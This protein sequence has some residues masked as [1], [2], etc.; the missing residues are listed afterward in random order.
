MGF[1][2][3]DEV[4]RISRR[5][6]EH[7][8][9]GNEPVFEQ[10]GQRGVE[11]TVAGEE[12]GVRQDA[13]AAELLDDSALGE[14]HRKNVT[15]GGQSD[16]DRKRALGSGTHNIAEEGSCK[17]APRREDLIL[18]HGGEVGD[19]GEHVKD[20]NA[21]E[22]HGS[23]EFE[24]SDGV[25]RLGQGVVRV[26]I[27][28]VRPDDIVES[29]DDSVRASCCS[30]KGVVEV[31]RVVDFDSTTQSGEARKDDNQEDGQLDES[32]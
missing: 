15:E 3:E 4:V 18:G 23:R 9:H 6:C 12:A 11:R 29:C 21:S 25:L 7:D 1:L 16:E 28:N 19:V 14:D 31:V 8:D 22:S 20:R 2:L 5:G 26:G 10:T 30:C 32:E 17:N 24:C 27:P 13:L